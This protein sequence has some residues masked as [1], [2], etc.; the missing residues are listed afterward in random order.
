MSVR[1]LLSRARAIIRRGLRR[2]PFVSTVLSAA[3]AYKAFIDA[4]GG[5]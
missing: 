1:Q 2:I 4:F 5:F 3:S